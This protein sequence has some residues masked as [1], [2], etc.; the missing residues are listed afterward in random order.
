MKAI[1]KKMDY[2]ELGMNKKYYNA[3]ETANIEAGRHRFILLKGYKSAFEIYEG[4]LKILMDYST[5]I[6][7]ESSL[8]DEIQGYRRDGMNDE[9]ICEQYLKGK[10]V[11]AMYGSQ[12]IYRI[13]EILLDGR[14]TDKFP[15]PKFPSFEAYYLQKYKLKIK[16]RDQFLIVHHNKFA[17]RDKLGNEIDKKIEKILLIP[18]F[19]HATGLTDEMRADFHIMKDLGQHTILN[20]EQRF[21]KIEEITQAINAKKNSILNFSINSNSNVIPAIQ[22]RPP[23]IIVGPENKFYPKEDRINLNAIV[24]SKSLYNWIMIFEP[25]CEQNID[26]VIDNLG[27]ASGRYKVKYDQPAEYIRLD[28]KDD[29]IDIEHK[30]KKSQKCKSPDIILFFISR[31]AAGFQYR[32]MKKHFNSL[33]IPTQFFVSFNPNK[34]QKGLSKFSNILLQMLNKIGCNLWYIDRSL[35]SSIVLGADCY[36]ARGNKSVAAVVSQFDDNFKRCYSVSSI[37]KREYE[38]IMKNVAQMVMQ[39]VQNYVDTLK[40]TPQ[41]IVFYRDGVGQGQ[42]REILQKE[43]A[44]IVNALQ[45]KYGNSRPKL[46]FIVVT[47]RIDDRF[48]MFGQTHRNPE[49]G[50]IIAKEVVKPDH[51]NFYMIAQKVTQGT[52]N[53]CHYDIIYN[54]ST[55]SLSDVFSLTYE[56]TWNYTNWMGPVKVPA[57]VQYAHKLCSLIGI[58]QD[59]AVARNL[60]SVRYYM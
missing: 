19:V 50:M 7:R 47:K 45:Q 59:S 8:W 10:S 21:K 33:G 25:F 29:P 46:L 5:R 15:D 56:L 11:L 27:K 38:E 48:A 2:I 23:K 36:H 32:K 31:K 12:K 57:P 9:A 37:Q 42:I 6:V 54:E 30:I 49:G 43:V 20:P 22:M 41:Q 44:Q 39:N 35:K 4:G 53:P 14:V 1:F 13:D 24:E 52:A 60:S 28:R 18:E 3:K 51:A 34:D 58:T 16:H 26:T 55:L 40:Q 17:I